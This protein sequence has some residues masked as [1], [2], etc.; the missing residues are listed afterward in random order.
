MVRGGSRRASPSNL[1]ASV[2]CVHLCHDSCVVLPRQVRHLTRAVDD[3]RGVFAP[4]STSDHRRGLRGGH[5]L[6]C[7]TVLRDVMVAPTP[8]PCRI[9]AGSRPASRSLPPAFVAARHVPPR[10]SA[11]L[12]S[13]A[14][15][16]G[17]H[18]RR[19]SGSRARGG[20]GC[21]HTVGSRV[22]WFVAVTGGRS[23]PGVGTWA[24]VRI[25]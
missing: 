17:E 7:R 8:T 21:C 10:A 5:R 24:S 15:S 6:E 2:A 14:I 1:G 18:S 9:Q 19:V 13:C 16:R 23:V 22:L 11:A 25:C 3:A 20:A 12:G 4:P